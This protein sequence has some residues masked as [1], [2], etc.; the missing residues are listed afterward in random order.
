MMAFIEPTEGEAQSA[1]D[2][3]AARHAFLSEPPEI[4]D[5]NAPAEPTPDELDAAAE[6]SAIE[7]LSK[8]SAPE[9][10]TPTPPPAPAPTSDPLAAYG[11]EEAVRTAFEVQQA[12]RTEQGV[13]ALVANGLSA[14]GY[15]PTQIAAAL[16]G[17]QPAPAAAAPADPLAGLDEAELVDVKTVR[18]LLDQVRSEVKPPEAAPDPRI[19]QVQ[20]EL[21][22]QR[23]Q[24]VRTW[25]D[26]A[27]IEVLGA[28][29]EDE[30]DRKTFASNVD[31]TVQR[32]GVYYDPTRSHDPLHVREC[33]VK[34]HADIEAEAEARLKAYVASKKR[35]RD[36]Q[37]VNVGGGSGSEGPLP[38]P[39][40]MQ[41][42]REQA[43]QSGFFS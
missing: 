17:E 39:K 14:L 16:N 2:I 23:Q 35:A 11:G 40:N 33:I 22:A 7:E 30:G 20:Q 24:Q 12:L 41:Q 25:T 10:V 5:N 18:A 42:A 37:P 1:A 9:G 31:A 38:E 43:R 3:A 21:A 29:P 28:P 6:A 26:A 27:I 15:D 34:A 8:P 19:E 13:R 32:A 36:S 4:F